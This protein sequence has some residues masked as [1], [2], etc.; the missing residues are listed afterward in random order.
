MPD[1]RPEDMTV[2]ELEI[3]LIRLRRIKDAR[4]E[5]LA[6]MSLIQQVKSMRKEVDKDA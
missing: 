5:E 3:E 4:H 2:H 1:K 6:R